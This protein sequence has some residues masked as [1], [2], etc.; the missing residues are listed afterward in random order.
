MTYPRSQLVSRTTAGVYHCV[1]RCIRRAWLCGDDP[2]IQRNF[3]YR[4]QWIDDRLA[5]LAG[6]FAISVYSFAAIP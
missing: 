4:R 5:L 2:L 3:D 1:S 6:R